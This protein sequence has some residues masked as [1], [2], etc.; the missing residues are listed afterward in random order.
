MLWATGARISEVLELRP[1]DVLRDSLVL[2]NRKNPHQA[3]KRVFL[4]GPEASLRGIPSCTGPAGCAWSASKERHEIMTRRRI[5]SLHLAM[6]AIFTGLVIAA[7]TLASADGA[8][9]DAPQPANWNAPGMAVPPAIPPEIPPDPRATARERVPE[10]LEDQAL[11]AVGWRL[12]APYQAGWGVKVLQA[13]S[14]YD[15]MGRPWDY[16]AFV[17]VDGVFAGTLSPTPMDSRTD[18]ALDRVTFFGDTLTAEFRR[19]TAA[20]PLCCP[21]GNSTVQYRVERTPQ[22]P[23]LVPLA[24]HTQWTSVEPASPSL[25]PPAEPTPPAP[26]PTAAA[27]PADTYTVQPGD[28]LAGI[29]RRVYGDA[30]AWPRLYTANQATIGGNP[31]RLRVGMVLVVPPAAAESGA[32]PAAAPSLV[33]LT[34]QWQRTAWGDDTVTTAQDPS[35]YT[36]TFLPDGRLAVRADCN[37]VVGTYAA[38]G[39]RLDLQLGASTRAFCGQASQDTDYLRMLGQ[40]A[41]YVFEGETLV[42]NMRLDSGNLYFTPAER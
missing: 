10:T 39:S 22:G 36:L 33:G 23:R 24:A 2:P 28:T 6:L 11:A 1:R 32:A 21:S 27:A 30:T 16:Q 25:T 12:F 29:A 9:L 8:W 17:F 3:I 14:S 31:D 20:D 15:G 18:G 34:W 26:A 42:L 41:T 13:T 35:H 40:V 19:Y 37:R 38:E 4:P 7:P 5:R